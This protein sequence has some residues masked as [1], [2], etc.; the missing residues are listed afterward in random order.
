ML[1][2]PFPHNLVYFCIFHVGKSWIA[3]T[4][5]QE[6]EEWIPET[7]EEGFYLSCFPWDNIPNYINI[8]MALL[9]HINQILLGWEG[10]PTMDISCGICSGYTQRS[11]NPL[12]PQVLCPFRIIPESLKLEKASKSISPELNPILRIFKHFQGWGLYHSLHG[13][14][15][16]KSD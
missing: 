2:D 8:E 5:Y 9:A 4:P 11:W 14:Q 10:N 13:N 3:S 6:H 1:G 15:E 12:E 7:G 16:M